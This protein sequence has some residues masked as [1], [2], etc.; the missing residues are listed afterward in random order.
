MA[1]YINKNNY[2]IIKLL[3]AE[4][5]KLNFGLKAE[6]RYNIIICDDC[7]NIC[8]SNEIYYVPIL[9]RI[10][11]EECLDDITANMEKVDDFDSID[12]EIK[13][14]NYYAKELNLKERAMITPNGKLEVYINGSSNN[15]DKT[16]T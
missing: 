12:Y 10:L 4:A 8:T 2:L 16:Y 13:H 6:D 15:I 11:C 1:K 9:N 3:P 7:N 5:T 14:F